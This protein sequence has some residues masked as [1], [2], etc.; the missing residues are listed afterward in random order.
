MDR[1]FKKHRVD[2]QVYQIR[3]GA[4]R[5]RG[6][7]IT[8]ADA[9]IFHL[10]ALLEEVRC[11]L[12]TRASLSLSRARVPRTGRSTSLSLFLLRFPHRS[13]GGGARARAG[14]RGYQRN[15]AGTSRYLRVPAGTF[16]S[17]AR[18]R[19]YARAGGKKA[20]E[21]D[22]FS[23]RAADEGGAREKK[24]AAEEIFFSPRAADEGGA[25]G[26]KRSERE[27]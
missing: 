23:P 24:K 4:W 6:S 8:A 5:G 22:F 15:P 10:Y 7:E 27:K 19:A 16:F 21:G 20:A 2:V 25:R 12:D 14:T 9:G 1:R 3:F 26:K 18:Q 17:R 11:S 13:G